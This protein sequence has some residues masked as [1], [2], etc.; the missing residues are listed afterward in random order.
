[1]SVPPDRMTVRTG[2]MKDPNKIMGL[3]KWAF[4]VIIAVGLV[5]A[6]YIYKRSTSA[7]SASLQTANAGTEP[8]T[9]NGL[10]AADIGGTPSDNSFAT[11]TDAMALEEQIQ[12]LETSLAQLQGSG[13]GNG[14]GVGV[15]VAPPVTD[16]RGPNPQ[17]VSAP[18]SPVVSS[19][20]PVGSSGGGGQQPPAIYA[21]FGNEIP[22]YVPR[23]GAFVPT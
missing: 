16:P 7:S 14:A 8:D 9:T 2:P 17:P 6:W 15:P 20:S 1:M 19:P 23:L 18:G 4:Y 5:L 10:T 3:P 11:N 21:P 22:P 13:G 12:Q